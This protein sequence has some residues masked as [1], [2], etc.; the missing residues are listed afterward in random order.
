MHTKEV[1]DEED[2]IIEMIRNIRRAYPNGYEKMRA[3][4]D[5][6]IDEATSPEED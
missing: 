5:E 6:L 2:D 3:Y 4:L 1:T